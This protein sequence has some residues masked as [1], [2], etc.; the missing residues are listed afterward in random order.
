MRPPACVSC[1]QPVLELIGQFTTLAP[2]LG[3][4]GSL[5]IDMAGS[6]HL[7]C[8]REAPAAIE[9]GRALVQNYTEVR[10]YDIVGRTAAWTVAHSPRT[11]E[12]LALGDRGAILPLTGSAPHPAPTQGAMRVYEPMFWLEWDQPVVAEIQ[13]TLRRSQTMPLTRVAELLGS[14][15]RLTDPEWLTDS[16]FRLDESLVDDWRAAAVGAAVDYAVRLP[17]ELAPYRGT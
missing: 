1:G 2:Y 3:A 15:Q 12:V 7:S 6:W 10:G 16:V 5:P 13:A 8:L 17:A 9:W 14:A 11:G 4:A